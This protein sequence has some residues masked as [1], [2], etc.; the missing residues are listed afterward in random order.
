MAFSFQQA[1]NAKDR[2]FQTAMAVYE[3]HL[4]AYMQEQQEDSGGGFGSI[5]GSVFGKFAGSA[6]SALGTAMVTSDERLKKDIRKVRTR[7]DG[8]GIYKFKYNW[9]HIE[10]EGFLAQ[11]VQKIYPEAVV[12]DEEGFL[13]VDYNKV[14]EEILEDV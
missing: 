12:A 2:K 5:I 10:R 14:P 1:E 9:G 4:Q 13:S 8:L 11:E 6:A 3:A 7:S